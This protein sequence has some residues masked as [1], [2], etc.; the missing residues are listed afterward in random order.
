MYDMMFA[1]KNTFEMQTFFY[2]N[3]LR[4]IFE[5]DYFSADLGEAIILMCLGIVD[6]MLVYIALKGNLK[7]FELS[8]NFARVAE[9]FAVEF[10]VGLVVLIL[11]L[12]RGEKSD[13]YETN[14]VVLYIILINGADKI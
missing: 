4:L 11:L 3:D 8:S 1:Q 9:G 12:R 13:N 7:Q 10:A 6:L 2:T 5:D 14:K